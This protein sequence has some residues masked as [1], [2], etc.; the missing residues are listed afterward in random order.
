M[1]NLRRRL[2]DPS[3]AAGLAVTPLNAVK[4]AL[5]SAFAGPR[6]RTSTAT[7]QTALQYWSSSGTRPL[8]FAQAERRG[9]LRACWARAGSLLLRYCNGTMTGY[10]DNKKR[11]DGLCVVHRN[12]VNVP[13][14]DTFA[15]RH[16]QQT[17]VEPRR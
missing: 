12:K 5:P 16:R 7:I 9:L 3:V 2:A 17:S 13:D 8:D 10:V 4:P 6:E 15:V 11:D 1:R 14:H